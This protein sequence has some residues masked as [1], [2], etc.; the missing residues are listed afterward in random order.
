MRTKFQ[1]IVTVESDGDEV[2]ITIEDT[3]EDQK[4]VAGFTIDEALRL[5]AKLSS[6]IREA[7]RFAKD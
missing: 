1:D 6:V 2:F 5:Q 4:A 7:V 3:K